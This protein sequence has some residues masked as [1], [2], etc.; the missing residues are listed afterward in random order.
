MPWTPLDIPNLTFYLPTSDMTGMFQ[1]STGT[2]PVTAANDPVY[3]FGD[4]ARTLA[5]AASADN[6][7]PVLMSDA[8]RKG[9]LRFWN[10]GS[11][12]K[13][14]TFTPTT[15]VHSHFHYLG[16]GT[17]AC[18][19]KFDSATTAAIQIVFDNLNG[20]SSGYG[21]T[22][23]R[24]ANEQMVGFV[25]RN[26]SPAGYAINITGGTI[27]DTNW[28]RVVFRVGPGPNGCSLKIDDN[29]PTTGTISTLG[30]VVPSSYQLRI[31]LRANSA[32]LPMGG[33]I[34]E[35]VFTSDVMTPEDEALWAAYNP[36]LFSTPNPNVLPPKSEWQ[37]VLRNPRG[38]I[39]AQYTH[40]DHYPASDCA[41]VV[42][43]PFLCNFGDKTFLHHMSLSGLIDAGGYEDLFRITEDEGVTWSPPKRFYLYPD[44]L[45]NSRWINSGA[46]VWDHNNERMHYVF[47]TSYDSSPEP[48]GAPTEDRKLWA[49]Y[50]DDPTDPESWSTPVDISSTTNPDGEEFIVA[51]PG[52][53]VCLRGGD[54]AGYL[55]IGCYT[56]VAEYQGA[57]EPDTIPFNKLI[58]MNPAVGTWVEGAIC[59]KAVAANEW[60][61]ETATCEL[62][63]SSGNWT[64]KI[65]MNC[66][67]TGTNQEFRKHWIIEEIDAEFLPP[68]TF[69]DK[70]TGGHVSAHATLG[71]VTC[72]NGNLLV[73][74]PAAT[75]ERRN[76][77]NIWRSTNFMEGMPTFERLRSPVEG[78]VGY[79]AIC[80]TSPGNY[81]IAYETNVNVFERLYDNTPQEYICLKKVTLEEL[82][83]PETTTPSTIRYHFNGTTGAT[84]S[85]RGAPIYNY[86]NIGEPIQTAGITGWTYDDLG[87]LGPCL[88]S[89]GTGLG[90]I[91]SARASDN[92]EQWGGQIDWRQDSFTMGMRIQIPSGLADGDYTILDGRNDDTATRGW[93]LKLIVASS[94]YSIQVSWK[95][96]SGG[97]TTHTFNN[98]PKDLPFNLYL[99]RDR[100][101]ANTV[102]IRCDNDD[103]VFSGSTATSDV[104]TTGVIGT[105]PV[106]LGSQSGGNEKLA[107]AI[108]DFI[109]ER[110]VARA[111]GAL[112]NLYTA[113]RPTPYE[114]FQYTPPTLTMPASWSDAK[115]AVGCTFDGGWNVG[116]DSYGGWDKGILPVQVG[117]PAGSMRC[118]ISGDLYRVFSDGRNAYWNSSVI[119]PMIR[120]RLF[121]AS[122]TVFGGHVHASDVDGTVAGD[123]DLDFIQ[124]TGNFAISLIFSPR[125]RTTGYI[126]SNRLNA[127]SAP[128][129]EVAWNGSTSTIDV[130][131]RDSGAII[132]EAGFPAV[133]DPNKVYYIGIS[134]S[135]G[136]W[137]GGAANKLQLYY[138]RYLNDT[139]VPTLATA[140]GTG[141]MS[142]A[143]D[144]AAG[145]LYIMSR[146]SSTPI[147]G[148][149]GMWK[150]L[151]IFNRPLTLAEH[152]EW[153]EMALDQQG[154]VVFPNYFG[155]GISPLGLGLSPNSLLLQ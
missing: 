133:I 48:T 79:S 84:L 55:V 119:G 66:R 68:A 26:N 80:T 38:V 114:L 100:T 149:D 12:S 34:S 144:G 9:S 61:N 152:Q 19:V 74:V 11:N 76:G 92:A 131:L 95:Y 49:M 109:F 97:N 31:G 73:C 101:S 13:R 51:G 8:T 146:N 36:D 24:N 112:T 117:Q 21:I 83:V 54:Y 3:V 17:A 132:S 25:A 44:F 98:P 77:M 7:R 137:D 143:S 110:G 121:S 155:L 52:T 151:I 154:T 89:A 145:A 2:T 57:T 111:D 113:T 64:G 18:W 127:G 85:A 56:R 15:Y 123:T 10:D 87:D 99:I 126:L 142:F 14:M 88:K 115:L 90:L 86:G 104:G 40:D 45:Q 47:T 29:A 60:T 118:L 16:I 53:G 50:S 46:F 33:Q 41:A 120:P 23:W 139:D 27:T 96:V 78:R 116:I 103:G 69:M 67:I 6:T 1:N 106:R 75:S 28:H 5:G 39:V 81:L 42:R 130:T 107:I 153:A 65:Y 4:T 134:G 32:D 43:Y 128:C 136:A 105:G 82:E 141:T 125:T 94:V 108:S 62:Q 72:D 147:S 91:M 148:V 22:L 135:A 93:T 30:A 37:R 20:G 124:N 58:Y 122:P 70:T 138:G 35:L 150:N 63:D 102:R 140:T 59:E 129:V 71:S